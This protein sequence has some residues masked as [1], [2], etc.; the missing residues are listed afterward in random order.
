[1]NMKS[2]TENKSIAKVIKKNVLTVTLSFVSSEASAKL[3][4]QKDSLSS[5]TK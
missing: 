1:M 4:N 3:L 2:N 5:P